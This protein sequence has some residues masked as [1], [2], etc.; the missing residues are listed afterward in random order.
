VR[1]QLLGNET[2]AA[3]GFYRE[4]AMRRAD[5]DEQAAEVEE[6]RASRLATDLELAIPV[7]QAQTATNLAKLEP[8]QGCYLG[9][10]DENGQNAESFVHRLGRPISIVYDYLDY[11]APFPMNWATTQA[12]AGRAIQIAWEPDDIRAV[13]NDNY[14]E[15]FA[16]EA[17]N[18][19]TGVFIRFGGEMNGNWTPWGRDSAAYVEAFRTVH[20]VFNRIAPNVAMVWAPN[21]VPLANLDRYYPGDKYVDWVGISVYSV[22]Y[23]DDDLSRP[24]FYDSPATMI[25]P[26][27][28]KYAGRKPLC[29]VE[30]GV[31]RRSRV[32]NTDADSYA[33]ARITDLMN[34]VRV[35]FPR[36]KMICFFDRNNLTGAIPGR[37]LNDYSMP[38][39]SSALAALKQAAADPYFLAQY[40]DNANSPM[41]YQQVLGSLP[42]GYSGA[43]LASLTTYDLHPSIEL[44]QADKSQILYRPY[45]GTIV[46][47]Y[48]PATFTVYDS[49]G[50]IAQSLMVAAPSF[51]PHANR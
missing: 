49:H 44:K 1:E 21:Q 20:D 3:L 12:N 10:R 2:L 45:C 5:G 51:N 48:G 30:C 25:E 19:G 27:Y 32:E 9:V 13:R 16:R 26:F 35:R 40:S 50:H 43:I 46:A 7:A 14:L 4:A 39:G 22:R 37:R 34:A 17:A 31:S 15:N 33:G 29:L 6:L 38:E 24:A 36:L 23:Y 41:A 47:N 42:S 28:K 18:C 11:G 8:D